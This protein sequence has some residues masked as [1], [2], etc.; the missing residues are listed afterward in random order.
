[1][2]TTIEWKIEVSDNL[3]SIISSFENVDS[4]IFSNREFMQSLWIDVFKQISVFIQ[5]RFSE[6][7][8]TWKA[9]TPKYEKWKSKAVSNSRS[10]DAGTFGKRVCKL[11]EIGRLTNTMYTS[12]TERSIDANIFEVKDN[13]QFTAGS[14]RY[15]ISGSKLPYATYFDSVRPFFFLSE[16]EANTILYMIMYNIVN[17]VYS[18]FNYM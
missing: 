2:P 8:G 12:A 16:E 9:L 4:S 14:F 18:A 10:V 7:S 5:K 13:P 6:G 1:M 17:K 11:N 3:H 15:A